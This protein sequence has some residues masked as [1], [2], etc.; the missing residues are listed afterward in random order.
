[1]REQQIVLRPVIKLFKTYQIVIVGDREFHSVDLAQWIDRQGVKFVLRQ[2]KDTT[3]RQK[4]RKFN[5]LSSIQVAPGQRKFFSEINIT[6]KKGFGRFNLAVYWRRKYRNK[7]EKSPWYLLTNLSDLETAVKA[8]KQ[9][10]GI[11]AMFKDCKTGGYNLEGSQA[12]PDKLVRL[13]LLIAI[14]MTTAWL[15]GEKISILGKSTYICRPKEAGR[16]KR[17]H[18]NFWVGL[19]GHNWIAAF[20]ECQEWVEQL[21][22]F[23]RNKRTFYQRGLKA[24]TLIQQAS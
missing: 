12:S 1:M 4:R 24:L 11:E 9:R 6:Q 14:A 8:Y 18:S 21:V 5:S 19:Y 13:I 7:Q 15:Q 17:R 23:V 16:T 22:T 3:F 2:K 10:W 20:H